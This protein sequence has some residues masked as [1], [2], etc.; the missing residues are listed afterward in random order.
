[1]STNEKAPEVAA[2]EAPRSVDVLIPDAASLPHNAAAAS[3]TGQVPLPD[4]SAPA[5]LVLL[6]SAHGMPCAKVLGIDAGK[7]AVVESYGR[8]NRWRV[9]ARQV[10]TFAALVEELDAAA[11][12]SDSI[13]I[14][15]TVEPGTYDPAEGVLRRLVGSPNGGGRWREAARTWVPI[16]FDSAEV[17]PELA[18]DEARVEYLRDRLP[19]SFRGRS[20]WF[21]WTSSHGLDGKGGTRLRVRLWFLA[22]GPVSD[23][24]LVAALATLDKALHVDV[25]IYRAVQ[26]IYVARPTFRDGVADPVPN[27]TGVV[28]GF[29]GDLVDA[30]GLPEPDEQTARRAFTTYAKRVAPVTPHPVG[31]A[32]ARERILASS[33]SRS[34]HMHAIGAA[35][36][37]LAL[38][39]EPDAIADLL[40]ELIAKQGRPANPGEVA[41]ILT[42][43][44]AKHASGEAVVERQPA[45]T[46]FPEG[47]EEE[48]VAAM[49]AP[50]GELLIRSALDLTREHPAYRA[51]I[52]DGLLREGETMNVIAAPKVGKSW[53]VLLMAFCI[54]NGV[55]F[56]GR[57]CAKG[58]VLIVDNELHPETAAQRLRHMSEALKLPMDGIHLVS[59]RGQLEDLP[60]LAERIIRAARGV[61]A[62][63]IFLDA[64]YRLLPPAT[65]ENDNAGMMQV[66]NCIDRIARASG[67]AVACVHHSS[68]GAQGEKSITDGGAGAGAISRAADCHMFLREHEDAGHIVVEAVARSWPPPAATVI[69]RNG[70]VW[71]VVADADPR[72]VK[73][74]RPDRGE[75]TT[76]DDIVRDFLPAVPESVSTIHA[77]IVDAGRNISRDKVA[78][79]LG[80]A[81]SEGLAVMVLGPR[82][83]KY[84][85]L[86]GSAP[87]EGGTH[88]DRVGA[89]L[90]QHPAAAPADVAAAVGCTERTVRRVVGAKARDAAAAKAA[91]KRR[92]EGSK[93]VA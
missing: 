60:K 48:G 83:A 11:R 49:P 64:L 61:G 27:R 20:C 57:S 41:G 46:L 14:R 42:W 22:D 67:A 1:M 23:A 75:G 82:C 32:N 25:S 85:G 63:V 54:A 30:A 7:L 19:E 21:Q 38:G 76:A 17:P 15:G 70:P 13:V 29:D 68:K 40:G 62:T 56:L 28:E 87:V 91:K 88:A 12:R 31:I 71:S 65:S 37:L 55:A 35:V 33:T 92:R 47:E 8:E 9:E 24:A 86:P 34:R 53:L 18:S 5:T 66:F 89:Y 59:L 93:G 90:E 74:R 81:E 45:A 80:L 3:D 84:Y 10:P 78:G 58:A 16:D 51:G 44:I 72:R 77:R 79:M 6:R 43:A 73:G 36:E 52:I 39:D 4:T 69:R 50:A 26:P 2:S